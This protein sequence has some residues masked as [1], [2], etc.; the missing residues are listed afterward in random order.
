MNAFRSICA[1][2]ALSLFAAVPAIAGQGEVKIVW[3]P[4]AGQVSK[5]KMEVDAEGDFGQG[6]MKIKV[7]M[8]L[9]NTVKSVSDKEVVIE[10][11]TTDMKVMLD[12]NELPIGDSGNDTSTNTYSL[13]G[14]LMSTKSAMGQENPRMEQMTSFRYPDKALKAGDSWT[15][16]VKGEKG[17]FVPATATY[18]Y[19][20]PDKVGKWDC[21][22][23]TF[24]YKETS[25]DKP[26]SSKGTIWIDTTTGDAVKLDVS[27]KD[28]VFQEGMPAM[29]ATAKMTRVE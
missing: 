21:H 20:G 8:G 27:M 13:N 26:S 2:G 5:Y 23:V 7:T 19:V 12:G 1:L 18:T 25:G 10:G 15:R 9:T 17:G 28:V 3:Q 29:N 4:K 22:K 24:E 14:D 16:E 11:K 6:P